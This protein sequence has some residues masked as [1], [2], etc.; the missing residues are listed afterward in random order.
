ME[1]AYN[2]YKYL[3]S[4]QTPQ[5]QDIQDQPDQGDPEYEFSLE[6]LLNCH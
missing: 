3:P 6:R 1:Q 5:I 4:V 2:L